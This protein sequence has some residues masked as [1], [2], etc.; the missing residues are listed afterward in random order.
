MPGAANAQTVLAG[1]VTD[2]GGRPLPG[3]SVLIASS[4]SGTTTDEA[5]RYRLSMP[6][7]DRLEIRF[8]Y[9]G[10]REEIREVRP[11]GSNALLVL[12]V[13]LNQKT[14]LLD[15]LEVA[16]TKAQGLSP[17]TY[18]NISKEDLSASDFGQDA[19]YLMRWTPSVVVTS[20]AGA[21]VGYTGIRVRGTDASRINVTV[22]GVPLND[23]ESQQVYWVDLP[24]IV[25]SAQEIQIQ[26]GVGTSTNGAGAFGATINVETNNLHPEPFAEL[27]FGGGSFNTL[28]RNIRFGSGL[29]NQKFAV[30]GRLS[31]ITSDGYVDRA[32]ADL[33]SYYLSAS[34]L[35]RN[36]SLQL[37]T[38]SGHEKTY[39]A[40]YGI[41]T[42][43]LDDPETRTF[44]PA[45]TEKEGEP[46]D[47]QVDDY[48]QTH[49]QLHYFTQLHPGWTL[50]AALHYTK[51]SGFYEEYKAQ[52]NLPDY[53]LPAVSIGDSTVQSSDLVRRRWLDNDFYGVTF[54][55]RYQRPEGPLKLTLGGAWN[56]YDGRHFGEVIWAR[57]ASTGEIRHPYYDND[58]TKTDFNLFGKMDLRL[59]Q[60][61]NGFLDLQVRRV[62]YTFLGLTDQLDR[63]EQSKSHT[64]FNPKAGIFYQAGKSANIYLSVGIANREPNRDDYV[65]N[66]V[67]Q[68]PRPERL[69][70]AEAGYRYKAPKGGFEANLYYMHY[71]DQLALNGRLNDDGAYIRIN[72]PDSYRLGLELAGDYLIGDHWQAHG[73]A[74]ISQNKV[75]SF[76]EYLDAYDADFNWTGQETIERKNT[77]LAFSPGV[78]AGGEVAWL[79][80]RGAPKKDLSISLLGKYIGRQYLDNSSDAR[81]ILPAYFFSDLRIRY[82]FHPKPFREI[83][84][85]FSVNN[86]T[87]SLYE[88]NGW[89]Y[90]YLVEGAGYVDQGFYPQAGR[91]FLVSVM[92]AF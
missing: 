32:S 76:T 58:A 68:Q 59:A 71:K 88:S 79:P 27:N 75:S 12:D 7:A 52:E 86:W 37:L 44:N 41:S 42:S 89:S 78:I 85:A 39:Q 65:D 40:W 83:G 69:I 3:A 14:F 34:L 60:K 38:F 2:P 46:Y 33:N 8:T 17:F 62:G 1:T 47:N 50:N 28:K 84:L 64:F 55:L 15:E 10:Y 61:L 80:L 26:R 18:T 43:M 25:S 35:G 13:Q 5:G 67:S 87:G 54:S 51:G 11:D 53:G 20:D 91:H 24:D 30:E 16:A 21:G 77:D 36:S 92:L 49:Y 74:T 23:A 72:I 9:L 57:F 73:T 70:N 31:R 63:L 45:G 56:R 19:P 48:Q 29:I 66:L 81:N 22:N 82:A 90:R 6:A 4:N